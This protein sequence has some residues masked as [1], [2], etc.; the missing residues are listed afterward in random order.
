M[1]RSGRSGELMETP[2][3]KIVTVDVREDIR[4]GREPF[5]K[6]MAA[7]DQLQP[8][9]ALLLINSFEPR[10]LYRVMAQSGF[11]HCTE[12]TAAGDWKVYFR[13]EAGHI[14]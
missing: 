8:D 5:E 10:P 3:S 14:H 12:Q 1:T 7:V 6:I 13:R 4:Q 11:T 9:E 2:S